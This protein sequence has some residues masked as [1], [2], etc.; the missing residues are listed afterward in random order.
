MNIIITLFY[1]NDWNIDGKLV[2]NLDIS[3]EI[4]LE[5]LSLFHYFFLS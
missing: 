3:L 2:F 4:F 1:T 5:S